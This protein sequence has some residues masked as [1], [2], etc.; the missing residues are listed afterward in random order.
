M[1]VIVP[2][3]LESFVQNQ[4]DSGTFTSKEEVVAE[5]LQLLRRREEKWRASA[6]GKIDEGWSKARAGQF[7]SPEQ[8]RSSLEKIK[9]SSLSM[10]S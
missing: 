9:P 6:S 5:G 7:L 8:A 1:T 4:L 3:T 2:A 10:L